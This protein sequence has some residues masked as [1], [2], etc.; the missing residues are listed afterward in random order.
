M[1]RS[2]PFKGIINLDSRDSVPD[3]TPYEQP[4]APDDAPNVLYIVWDDVGFG[5]MEVFG[6]LIE[7]PNMQRLA[8]KGLR[9]TQFHTTA[10]CS[11]TRSSLL[12]GR[13]ATSN[14]MASITE[15][16]N[17]FPGHC[18][19]IPFENGLIS[20]V[21]VEQGWNTYALGKWHLTP[22]EEANLASSRRLWPLGRG[23]ER[24][25]GFLGGETNQWYPDLVEDNHPIRQPYTP[26][27]G[28]H[29]SKDLTDKAIQFVRDA[30]VIAPEKPWLMYFC[31]GAGHAPHHVWKEWAD[32]YKGRFDMGY[33]R[34]R[35][36]VLAN[37]KR[38][39]LV[40]MDIQL[41]PLNPYINERSADGK[42]WPAID[43][44][45]PWDELSEEEKRLFSRMAEVY[46]GY[47]SYTDQQIGRLLDYLEESGQMDNTIII[48]LSDNGASGEGGPNG[49]VNE[50]NFFNGVPDSIEENLKYLD[51]LGSE[52]TY[53]HYPNG[54]A[55]GFC[56]PFKLYK[57]YAGWEGGIADP[58]IICW[59]KGIKARGD[60]RHQY[61][62]AIDVVPTIYDCLGITPPDEIKGWTQS[63]IEGISFRATFDDP[64]APS[65][66]T[67]F[68]AMAGT[69]GIWHK[70]WHAN[71]VHPP[72]PC[73]WG[74]FT[75]DRW[76]LFHLDEDRNQMHNLADQHP[77]KLE[78]LKALWFMQA[79]LYKGIPCEDR[80]AVEL[81]NL[82]RPQLTTPRNRYVY[83]PG[84]SEVP[85][86]VAVSVCGR[87]YNIAVEVTIDNEG[88]EGVLFSHGGR[89]G[90]HSL[91]IKDG[92]LHYVYNWLGQDQ[93]KLTSNIHVPTG[94][95]LLGVR[96]RME[97][98]EGVSPVGM[99]ALYINGQLAAERRIRTQPGK[100]S[101]VGE[102]L[103][104]GRDE[105]E[106]VSSDYESPFTFRGGTIKQATVD[107]SG[108]QYRDLDKELQAM[109]ARD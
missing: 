83:Y 55:I 61:I 108:E 26:E 80:S 57:R 41:P 23:F 63:P 79:G 25:Y 3:W 49:S 39:G 95:S 19:R 4:K 52:R 72:A 94:K 35:E 22:A 30:K 62:H 100:F 97:G 102:G 11:P 66:E 99:A 74:H 96:F 104:V 84:C 44:A 31:P 92:M 107:V 70:G 78:E 18:G 86:A 76:E 6:G 24:Y 69:R 71:A 16:T 47:I 56:T 21:L 14:G 51:V 8:D 45:R 87:S 105:G 10:L 53:N 13:N 15:A 88:A 64:N 42:P 91:Y 89:F 81:L 7:T 75:Q 27:E 17:G 40:P 12:T 2:K 9:Y 73:D 34:Y 5:A 65:K 93:Q 36:L 106:P 50:N 43:I 29:L 90:G 59:P 68:Y 32:K 60:I 67:Q 101:L 37:Q 20:E 46:A 109:F 77:D 98:H 1:P 38:M 82:P 48:A 33:E 54:W 85:E 28:Y 103:A 58:F